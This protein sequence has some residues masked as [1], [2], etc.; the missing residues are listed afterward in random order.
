MSP[1]LPLTIPQDKFSLWHVCVV[2]KPNNSDHVF[3]EFQHPY[4]RFAVA[5]MLPLEKTAEVFHGPESVNEFYFILAPNNVGISTECRKLIDELEWKRSSF[6]DDKLFWRP[7]K[8]ILQ[9]SGANISK[10][11]QCL[12]EF[13]FYEAELRKLELEVNENWPV[14][15]EDIQFTHQ[16]Q[17]SSIKQS[18]HINAMTRRVTFQ[19]MR[20]V[21][22]RAPLEVIVG[23]SQLLEKFDCENRLDS[24]EDQLEIYEDV[25]ELANDRISEFKYFHS[26]AKLE[27]YIIFILLAEVVI[28]ILELYVMGK[29]Y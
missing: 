7:G 19:R 17:P 1:K 2:E 22:M 15:E 3:L 18:E 29:R 21:R 27:I 5:S 20:Q 9:I 6:K 8:G 14:V 10:F 4:K 11:L 26:E 16:V 12:V 24:L 25:Y 28:M 23:S 13:S